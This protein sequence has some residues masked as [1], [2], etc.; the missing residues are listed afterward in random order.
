MNSS[1]CSDYGR[2]PTIRTMLVL[3]LVYAAA[4]L[5]HFIHNAELITVYPGLPSSWTR[6]GVYLAWLVMTVVGVC[7][8]GLLSRG[9]RLAGSVVLAA[10]ALLG[11]DSLGHYL[12]AP[13]SSHTL[14]MNVTILVEVAAAAVVLVQAVKLIVHAR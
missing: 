14:A 7:G 6:G 5:V 9:Y 4:S 13:F 8:W 2:T 1:K 12:M 10:Y 3:L 11:L